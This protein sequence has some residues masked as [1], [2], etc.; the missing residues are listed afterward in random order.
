MSNV[1]ISLSEK[2][3]NIKDGFLNININVALDTLLN[4]NRKK[5]GDIAPGTVINGKYIVLE[6]FAD[7]G[8][9]VITKELLEKRM[10][11]GN[12]NNF[13]GS[14]VDKYLN[15]EYLTELMKE[16]CEDQILEHE[17]DLF[18]LDGLD[19]YGKVNRK[20]SLLTI[21]QYRKYRKVL[22]KNMNNWWWLS[23]PHSTPSGYSA[24]CVRYVDSGGGVDC[25]DC[26]YAGGLRPF[27][28]LRSSI[29][30]SVDEK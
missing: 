5:L 10:D 27:C 4:M 6:H 25:D 12:D 8:T 18:S 1:N 7:G 9:A 24:V 22:G 11:Y 2:D 14:K 15:G 23:T 21:D 13:D 30:V 20:V 17:V 28:V 19:D 3:V 16:F 29:F 26:S